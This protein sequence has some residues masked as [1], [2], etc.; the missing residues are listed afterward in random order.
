MISNNQGFRQRGSSIILVAVIGAL[1]LS[2]GGGYGVYTY[3][4]TPQ[5]A[6]DQIAKAWDKFESATS[7]SAEADMPLLQSRLAAD[8]H[9]DQLSRI[10]LRVDQPAWQWTLGVLLSET[11]L[12]AQSLFSQMSALEKEIEQS[13]PITQTSTYQLL[14]P[15]LYGQKW[16]HMTLPKTDDAVTNRSDDGQI[17]EKDQKKIA[18]KAKDAIVVRQYNRNYNYQ[19]NTYQRIVVG[20]KKDQLVELLEMMKDLDISVQLDQINALIKLVK[21]VATWDDDLVDILIDKE[22]HFASIAV[23]LPEIPEEALKESIREGAG[24]DSGIAGMLEG[25]AGGLQQLFKDKKQGK[26]V[27]VG[28]ITLTNYNNAPPVQ[29]PQEL[30]EFDQV[31]IYAQQEFA[32]I[33]SQLM[34]GQGLGQPA[35]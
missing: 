15:A 33:I 8:L 28:T 20:L 7:V 35:P 2:V 16:F 32:P 11:D 1:L 31:I 14:S 5:Q 24:K 9:D 22:G 17:S 18:Q 26:L 21:S 30:V 6:Q 3:Y 23:S 34:G 25:P 12:Y 29:Q 4:I 13:F 27:Q 19:G 10:Q